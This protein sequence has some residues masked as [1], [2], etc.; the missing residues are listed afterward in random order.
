MN[1]DVSKVREIDVENHSGERYYDVYQDEVK[2]IV[3]SN[4]LESNRVRELGVDVLYWFSG[5]GYSSVGQTEL[6]E[7]VEK[8]IF[9]YSGGD[10][11]SL[12]CDSEDSTYTY[13]VYDC[14][15]VRIEN[16]GVSLISLLGEGHTKREGVVM[17]VYQRV[18]LQDFLEDNTKTNGTSSN[19]R[20]VTENVISSCDSIEVVMG[21]KCAVAAYDKHKDR[22]FVE[23]QGIIE[24]YDKWASI[25][26]SDKI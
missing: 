25:V 15:S 6:I 4:D 21:D 18:D 24:D 17:S 11:D 14:S 26:V 19:G 3:E 13:Y 16:D 10:S 22:G 8:V 20:I 2:D 1:L 7:D 23:G 9:C 5:E 12:M